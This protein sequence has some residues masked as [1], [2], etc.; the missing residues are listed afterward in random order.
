MTGHKLGGQTA[1]RKT[2]LW[3][4]V[5]FWLAVIFS[6]SSVAVPFETSM[7]FRYQDKLL[8]FIEFG[9]LGIL[10]ARSVHYAHGSNKRL[11]WILL[12]AGIFYGGLDEYHQSFVPGRCAD[13]RDLAADGLGLVFCAWGWLAAKGES[14]VP[15]RNERE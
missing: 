13:W 9:V 10:L 1:W 3:M 11:L 12:I 6:L 8:H 2:A 15:K 4:P 5:F 7:K 14:L